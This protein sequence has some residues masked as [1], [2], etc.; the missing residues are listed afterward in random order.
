MPYA[1]FVKSFYDCIKEYSNC[2]EFSLAIFAE[3]PTALKDGYSGNREYAILR[4]KYARD[5]FD[6]MEKNTDLHAPYRNSRVLEKSRIYPDQVKITHSCYPKNVSRWMKGTVSRK[7]R[8]RADYCALVWCWYSFWLEEINPDLDKDA[9]RNELL[10]ICHK[11]SEYGDYF[12]MEVL[13][14]A[15]FFAYWKALGRI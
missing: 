11:Y 12:S 10:N 7:Q 2:P 5:F 13:W 6:V 3:G 8:C 14:H 4:N 1:D 9:L 15:N